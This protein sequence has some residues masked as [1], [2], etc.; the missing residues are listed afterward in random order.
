MYTVSLGQG[1]TVDPF[2]LRGTPGQPLSVR[3]DF[4][5]STTLRSATLAFDSGG[6]LFTPPRYKAALETPVDGV[7]FDRVADF[8]TGPTPQ[9]SISFPAVT[10]RAARIVFTPQPPGEL[11]FTPVAGAIELGVGGASV[12][13][14]GV[15]HIDGIGL[16]R[17]DRI[18]RWEENAGFEA[19]FDYYALDTHGGT[20]G[21]VDPAQVIDLTS[22]LRPDGTIHWVAPRGQWTVLRFGWSLTGKEN[23]PATLEATGLEVDKYDGAAVGRYIDHYLDTYAAT[24]GPDDIGRRGIRAFLNDSIEVGPANW[25]PALLAEFRT[26]RGY[27]PLPWLPTLT[28]AIVG[29][30]A[31]SDAFRYDFAPADLKPMIDMEFALGVNLPVIHTSVHQPV[32]AKAPGLSLAIFGQHFN[33]LESGS[34]QARPWID[35]IARSAF[36]LQQGRP[37]AD[38]LYFYGEKAPLTALYNAAPPIDAPRTHDW[39]FANA[40]VLLTQ[41]RNDGHDLVTKSGQRY[42]LLWLGGMSG[43]TTL[44]VLRRVLALIRDGAVVSGQRA[45]Q[46]PSLADDPRAFAAVAAELWGPPGA[47]TERNVGRGRVLA[48][49]D[50]EDALHQI[51][52]VPDV[53]IIGA[54]ETEILFKHRVLPD[55]G[56]IY[57]I[58]NRRAR[59]ERVELRTGASGRVPVL[60]HA[61]RGRT[62]PVTWH[63]DGRSTVVPLD[64]A[65]EQAVFLV[66]G[67]T[68]RATEGT[69][70]GVVR[71]DL[72][73]LTG[74]WSLG[75]RRTVNITC[76]VSFRSAAAKPDRVRKI[77]E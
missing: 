26:R 20:S 4:A 77:S 24:V 1:T 59:A 15:V 39:D 33:R 44:P 31:R 70:P 23:H 52:R 27:D 56:H 21:G 18:H 55:G 72:A 47:V 69:A 19:P 50:A 34:E 64:L 36:M 22:R 12:G 3:Y 43:R 25:T 58:T 13:E 16:S 71:T 76:P 7:R 5:A 61:D 6:T 35:Y 40:D 54:P 75:F 30:A 42:P 74:D 48:A 65:P 53:A 29:D 57:F 68:T 38:V 14:P 9:Y 17:V 51:G 28:G 2:A 67:E 41:V 73:Y 60:W 32:T 49:V 45:T 66:M 8:P 10:A 11:P 63:K 46:S 62:E 37:V